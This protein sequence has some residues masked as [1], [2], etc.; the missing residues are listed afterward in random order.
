MPGGGAI[1][2][3]HGREEEAFHVLS[4]DCG[5]VNGDVII[6]AGPGDL[7]FVP[8]GNRRG[9]TGT[10]DLPGGLPAF[11]MLGGREGFWLDTASIRSPGRRRRPW[12]RR[13]SWPHGGAGEAPGDDHARPGTLTSRLT[14]SPRARR[15]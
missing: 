14:G 15:R 10:G 9:S 6:K 7:R 12:P 2:H 13:A 3:A 5:F 8:R 1:P 11:I 4:G